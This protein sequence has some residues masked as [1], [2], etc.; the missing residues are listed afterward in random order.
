MELLLL[1]SS[2]TPAGY[3]TEYLP[4]IKRFTPSVRRAVSFPLLPSRSRGRTTASACLTRSASNFILWTIW[5]APTL[6]W[7]AAETHSSCC[8]NAARGLLKSIAQ[9]VQEGKSRYLGWS[10][11]AN[12]ACPTIKTTND[13]PIVDPGG[14]DALGLI[15][16][17]LKSTISLLAARPPRRDAQ[18][19]GSGNSRA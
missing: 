14:L 10:A 12:L 4:E 17:Q 9:R 11:G 15:A 16:F 1:S 13:M 7:L 8:A 2:R 3:F 19:P 18:R 5:K 6:S